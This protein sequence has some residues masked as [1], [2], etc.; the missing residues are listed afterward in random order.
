MSSDTDWVAVTISPRWNSACT[1]EAGLASILSAKSDSEEPRASRTTCAVAAGQGDAAD[2]RRLHVVEFL[3]ALLLGLAA[4]AGRRRPDD[5]THPR[6]RR[7]RDRRHPD[8]T[9]TAAAGGAPPPPP[10]PR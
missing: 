5:R 8:A 7:G 6:H 9:A 10:G 4:L 3:T 1:I 2:R